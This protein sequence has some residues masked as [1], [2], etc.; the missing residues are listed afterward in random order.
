VFEDVARKS[1]GKAQAHYLL[2]YL[3]EQQGRHGDALP[4]MRKA[5]SIDPQYLSAWLHLSQLSEHV[6][7][8]PWEVDIARLKLLELDPMKRHVRYEIDAVGNLAALWRGAAIA[9]A[10]VQAASPIRSDVFVLKASADAQSKARDS[11]PA[12]MLDQMRFLDLFASRALEAG[13]GIGSEPARV[14]GTHSFMGDVRRLIGIE[15]TDGM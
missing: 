4:S 10:A 11:L 5:V 8:E 14:L 2:G 12:E 6:H 9:Q 3:R 13:G 7:I 1:P 15:A